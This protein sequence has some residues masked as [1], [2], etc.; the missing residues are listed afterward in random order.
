MLYK[1]LISKIN[2]TLLNIIIRFRKRK[3]K[4]NFIPSQ[5]E[6]RMIIYLLKKKKILSL[7]SSLNKQRMINSFQNFFA[8]E[9]SSMMD[10][11]TRD[12][13]PLPSLY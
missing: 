6:T 12:I 3:E 2:Y 7:Q 13:F 9:S 11:L 4:Q 1:N 10:K 8:E 5:K